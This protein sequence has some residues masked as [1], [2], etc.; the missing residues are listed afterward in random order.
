MDIFLG[1]MSPVGVLVTGIFYIL[2]TIFS[3]F[4]VFKSEKSFNAFLW[5]LFIVFLPFIGS[6]VYLLKYYIGKNSKHSI[7]LK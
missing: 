1:I 5:A 6:I 3:L 4:L 7:V 2:I